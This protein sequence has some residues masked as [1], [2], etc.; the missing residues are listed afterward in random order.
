MSTKKHRYGNPAKRRPVVG[1]LQRRLQPTGNT[2]PR[3]LGGS[4]IGD[5]DPNSQSSV[6]LDLTDCVLLEETTVCMVDTV[7]RGILQQQAIYLTMAG[8][9]N[10]TP[11]QVQ[12][13]YLFDSDGAAAL[14]SQ[15][16]SLAY[17]FGAE[18]LTDLVERLV[19]LDQDGHGSIAWLKAALDEAQE[20]M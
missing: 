4:I 15:L 19:T 11:D 20:S 10:N 7:R 8:R 18:M 13:G 14:I 12:V 9:V 3:R 5:T 16:L 1:D 6:V 17:R 2:D